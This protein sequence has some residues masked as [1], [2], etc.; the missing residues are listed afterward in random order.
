MIDDRYYLISHTAYDVLEWNIE[1]KI[2]RCEQ[3][4]RT[5]YSLLH[6]LSTPSRLSESVGLFFRLFVYDNDKWRSSDEI[7][8]TVSFFKTKLNWFL[9]WHLFDSLSPPRCW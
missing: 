4:H 5:F 6:L 3:Y 2:F 8:R 1:E 7:F 9:F